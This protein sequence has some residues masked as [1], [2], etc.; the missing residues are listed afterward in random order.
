MTGLIAQQDGSILKMLLLCLA[1]GAAIGLVNGVGVS[2]FGVPSLIFTLGTNSVVRG[3]I[4][5][6]SGGRTI[7]NF[8]GAISSYGNK[9]VF[10]GVTLYYAIA[11][12]L[13]A[14]SHLALTKTR[15]GKYFIAVGDNAGGAN[16][17]RHLRAGHEDSGVCALRPVRGSGRL[18]VR[19]KYGQVMTVAGNGYE[20]TAIAACVL[21][22]ISLSGGL[23]N[24]V[25]ARPSARSSYL[26]LADCWSS[27]ACRPPTTTPSP[28]RC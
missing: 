7:E 14:I 8:G 5:I 1:T 12:V 6:M 21:G 2:Y 19:L 16:S 15:K 20:M 18:R 10:A 23:G 25:G 27:S 26:P 17:G 28:A 13:V 3:L 11:V 24:V 9:T 22:G 4:Y